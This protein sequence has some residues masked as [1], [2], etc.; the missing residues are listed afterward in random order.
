M[1]IV[2]VHAPK[3]YGIIC[4]NHQ[5]EGRSGYFFFYLAIAFLV[6]LFAYLLTENQNIF[7]AKYMFYNYIVF[8]DFFHFF[9]RKWK[10]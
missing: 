2:I 1:K 3:W 4:D 10:S 6:V 7:I 9:V 5:Y 8:K